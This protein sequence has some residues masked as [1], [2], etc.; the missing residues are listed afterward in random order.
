MV[1]SLVLSLLAGSLYLFCLIFG[2]KIQAK[3]KK[4]QAK[5]KKEQATAKRKRK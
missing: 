4:E 2:K 5:Y 1:F 3:H